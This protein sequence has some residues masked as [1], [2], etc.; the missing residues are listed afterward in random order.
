MNFQKLHRFI[1]LLIGDPSKHTFENR[2]FTTVMLSISIA[3]AILLSYDIFIGNFISQIIDI[4]CIIYSL[5][6]YIYS[7][8]SNNHEKLI[9]PTFSFLYIAIISGWFFNNGIHGGMPF[10]FFILSCYSC[11]FFKKP[12][13]ISIPTITATVIILIA[14]EYFHPEFVTNYNSKT[15]HFIDIGASIFICLVTNGISIHIIYKRYDIERNLNK[16]MLDQAISN[17]ELIEKSMNEIQILRGFLPICSHCK[18]IKDDKGD[19]TQ[20][21]LFIQKNSEAQFSHSLCPECAQTMYPEFA[22][23]MSFWKTKTVQQQQTIKFN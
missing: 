13:K 12:F 8:K 6:G 11:V 18:K 20:L 15:H 10:F 14:I 23:K 16:R 2:I 22:D 17:K 5:S 19:W 9:L 7:I 1:S 3:G 4:S 21:E